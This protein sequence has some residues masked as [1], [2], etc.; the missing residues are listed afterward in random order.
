MLIPDSPNGKPLLRPE[1]RE[2]GRA[3]RAGRYRRPRRSG[4]GIRTEP[5]SASCSCSCRSLSPAVPNGNRDSS[6]ATGARAAAVRAGRCRRP[7]Q[8]EPGFIRSDG[9]VSCSCSCRPLSPDPPNGNRT[10]YRTQEHE[11]QLFVPVAVAGPAERE[12]PPSSGDAGNASCSCS[13]WPLSPDPPNGKA[14]LHPETPGTQAVAACPGH[15]SRTRGTGS[16]PSSGDTGNASCSCLCWSLLPDPPNGK[17]RLHP[18]HQERKL[19]LLVLATVAGLAGREAQLHPETPG[20][21]AAAACVGRCYRTRRTGSPASSETPGAQAVAARAGHCRRTRGTGSPA[22]SGDTGSASCSC[23]CRPLVP[24]AP[25]GSPASSET[26]G[27]QAVA[28][29]AGHCRRTRGTGSPASSGDT[30][31]ASC[32]CSCRPLVPEAP[33][34]SPASSGVQEARAVA[35]RFGCRRTRRMV[36]LASARAPG[37]RTVVVGRGHCRRTCRMGKR[38]SSG[39]KGLRVAAARAGRCHRTCRREVRLRLE[40]RVRELQL[41]VPAPV[42]DAPNGKSG[43]VWSAGC[44]SCSCSCRPLSPDPRNG[45][46]GFIQRRR[47]RKLQ[48]LVLA[49]VAGPA[50][51]EAR[52]VQHQER[53]LQLL[54]LTTVARSAEREAL[55]LSGAP[56]AQAAVA[57]VGRCRWPRR[58]MRAVVAGAP[59]VAGRLEP[60]FIRSTSLHLYF[61]SLILYFLL[62]HD[63]DLQCWEESTSASPAIGR[64]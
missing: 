14:H 24:E 16:P 25:K 4:T 9:S 8:R 63:V 56:G 22:S 60:G 42:P 7:R 31:S 57:R 35:A 36:S 47:E 41:L 44:E 51:W 64:R 59:A 46:P 11:V 23:S 49:T 48:L 20:A 12:S 43:F 52:L 37:V 15:C 45:K 10:S 5:R 38:V 39:A 1:R 58:R 53:K 28:A 26:P 40:C 6:G 3:A 17:P 62:T 30:G 61:P 29:R 13:C 50:E 21:Q 18:G 54:V 33:K 2:H 34:G 55:A 19:Q 32:S 27:A